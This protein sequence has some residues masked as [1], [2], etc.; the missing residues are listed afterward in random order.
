VFAVQNPSPIVQGDA[1]L[2]RLGPNS[3]LLTAR[4]PGTALIRVHFTHYWA[5]TTGA[6]CVAPAGDFTELRLRRPG[7]V[8]LSIRFSLSR[9][10]A[11]SPRCT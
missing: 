1:H 11:R 9:I 8:R 5:I 6:G 10:G 7:Q 3:L 4:R 2:D